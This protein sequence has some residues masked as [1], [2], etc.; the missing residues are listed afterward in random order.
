MKLKSC[1]DQTLSQSVSQSVSQK[2]FAL[3]SFALRNFAHYT[4]SESKECPLP[5]SPAKTPTNRISALEFLKPSENTTNVRSGHYLNAVD[6]TFSAICLVFQSLY[7][8]NPL[9]RINW[10]GKPSGNGENPDNWIFL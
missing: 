8:R 6:R 9:I 5:G 3:R 2:V 4:L 1:T 10:D 7:R